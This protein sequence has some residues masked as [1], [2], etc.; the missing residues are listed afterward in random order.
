MLIA[1]ADPVSFNNP[2]DPASSESPLR[3]TPSGSV[4]VSSDAD[5]GDASVTVSWSAVESAVRYHVQISGSPDFPTPAYDD[6]QLTVSPLSWAGANVDTEYWARI[7]YEVTIDYNG[8]VGNA[9][10]GWTNLGSDNPRAPLD[11]SEPVSLQL[12]QMIAASFSARGETH[13]FFFPS[14]SGRT[15]LLYL[16]DEFSGLPDGADPIIEIR[17]DSSTGELIALLDENRDKILE[18]LVFAAQTEETWIV[19]TSDNPANT[20]YEILLAEAGGLVQDL[21]FPD[22]TLQDEVDI[23]AESNT[24]VGQITSISLPSQVVDL[25][26]I[27]QLFALKS[28]DVDF[29]SGVA[30]LSPV[31]GLEKLESLNVMY[32]P[33]TDLSPLS[34]M[35][36]LRELYL[37]GNAISDV[38]PLAGLTGLREVWVTDTDIASLSPMLVPDSRIE[39]L[40]ASGTSFTTIAGIGNL[41]RLSEVYLRFTQVDTGVGEIATL[42]ALTH[43]DLESSNSIP[44]DDVTAIENAYSGTEGFELIRPDG[45]IFSP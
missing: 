5:L 2:Y 8:Q 9:W 45:S 35:T 25:T 6:D 14:V 12:D 10:S 19:I 38:T 34:T 41:S 15:Y 28:L 23:R 37:D 22:P 3:F 31:A 42:P 1:C 16:N 21:S 4:Q 20:F 43:V 11:F 27:D 30:D 29:F 13:E 44:V 39:I 26:G 40:W 32:S 36:S 33:V 17:A 18:P 7:R 24:Y